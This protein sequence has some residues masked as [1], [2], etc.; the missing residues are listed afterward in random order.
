MAADRIFNDFIQRFGVPKKIHHD[1]GGEF[2]NNLFKRLEQLT[3][4]MHSR[5]TPYHPQ[6]NGIVERMNRTL[7]GMLR[8]LPESYKSR[9]KDHLN[10]LIHAYNCTVYESTN[11]SPFYLLF[12]RNPRLL[13][14]LMFDLPDKAES[15]S[16]S[17]YVSKWKTAMTEA[18]R[19]AHEA[20]TKS[21][22][23]GKKNYDRRIRYTD[24]QPGD[25]VLVRNL[26]P[27]G[28]PGKLRAFWEEEVHVVV[29]RKGPEI[30]VYELRPETGRGRNRVLHRNLLLPCEHLPLE[31]W[32]ELT[33]KTTET[34]R[35][36]KRVPRNESEDERSNSDSDTEDEFR[37]TVHQPERMEV[38]P[39]TPDPVQLEIDPANENGYIAEDIL[40]DTV[41]ENPE[42]LDEV[43][44]HTND[45]QANVSEENV[46]GD[47]NPANIIP[48][49]EVQTDVIVWCE[50]DNPLKD[51]HIMVLE[52]QHISVRFMGRKS[53]SIYQSTTITQ[54]NLSIWTPIPIHFW[55]PS[56]PPAPE[57]FP[58][59]IPQPQFWNP[60]PTLPTVP[61]W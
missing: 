20:T 31:N 40:Q 2:E 38:N 32:H 50:E 53:S 56:Y 35:A 16:R 49:P 24:L 42:L 13:I 60:Y 33:R 21:A 61:L 3:G 26:S 52:I 4:V 22:E 25:R 28:G 37:V 7:L 11:Y 54:T 19:I 23:K 27:R 51:S 18:Y 1:M 34:Q 12:G 47:R 10:K 43:Q 36:T 39:D 58:P 30:P 45:T 14:D 55:T 48:D 59:M 5:T 41:Q 17:D 29:S 44:D 46:H 8:T 9:W 15:N 57:T 6:G